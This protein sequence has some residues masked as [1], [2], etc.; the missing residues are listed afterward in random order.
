MVRH[1][2]DTRDRIVQTARNLFSSYGFG[3]TSLHDILS[4]VGITKG[5][6]YHYFKSKE[7]LGEIVLDQAVAEHHHAAQALQEE[8]VGP[9]SLR[10]WLTLITEQNTSGQWLNGRLLTRMTIE[11]LQLSP[12]MQSRLRTFWRWYQ[13]FYETLLRR[14]LGATFPHEQVPVLARHLI[15][16]QFGAIWLDRCVRP[17][18]DPRRA[19]A[20]LLDSL[21]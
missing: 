12:G 8:L 2:T 13:N 5:A 18:D 16:S 19:I 7:A 3:G 21:L 6:F 20:M 15:C 1:P 17:K 14:S 4:A 9:D 11:C 10:R